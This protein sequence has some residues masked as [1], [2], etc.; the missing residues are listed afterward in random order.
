MANNHTVLAV[1][2]RSD[3]RRCLSRSSHKLCGR[4]QLDTI[5][6]PR[7]VPGNARP[8]VGGDLYLILIFTG[9][10]KRKKNDSGGP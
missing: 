10:G 3:S 1:F 7:V 4:L 9:R 6:Q 5:G 2:P 8:N